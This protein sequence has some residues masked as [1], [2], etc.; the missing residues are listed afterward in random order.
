MRARTQTSSDSA[1]PQ[2]LHN[3]VALKRVIAGVKAL[4][5]AIRVIP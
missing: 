2:G 1:R 4:T 5:P 3:V